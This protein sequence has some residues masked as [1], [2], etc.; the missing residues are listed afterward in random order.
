MSEDRTAGASPSPDSTPY[1]GEDEA[2]VSVLRGLKWALVLA[3]IALVVEGIGAYYSRSLSLTI[4]AIHNVPDIVAYGASLGALVLAARGATSSHTYGLHRT[5]VMAALL[6]A[7]LVI[8]TALVFGYTAIAALIAGGGSPFG[9]ID[10]VW[11]LFAAVPT[12]G[13]RGLATAQV[14]R[15]PGRV[16]D[17]NLRSVLFHLGSDL[18][19]V[20]LIVAVGL[21]LLVR[22]SLGWVDP[23]AALAIA[24][25]LLFESVPIIRDSWGSLTERMPSHL[26][27]DE[28][29]RTAMQVPHVQA[30]HDVHVWSVC[31]S[32]VCMTARV[33]MTNLTVRESMDV[34]TALRERMEKDFGIVHAIF[35]VEA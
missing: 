35:E 13:L 16:R 11:L 26:S 28:I 17:I 22:A 30:M 29:V 6:N 20:A 1:H 23:L 14:R 2:E 9:Q 19:I 5:E 12:L 4:D 25:I 32:L 24:A 33:H 3:G 15:I 7:S 8:A 31:S 21:V 18:V 10:P 34:L 27:L